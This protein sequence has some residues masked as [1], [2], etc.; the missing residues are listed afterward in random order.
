ME[1]IASSTATNC[2][3]HTLFLA[4]AS[5]FNQVSPYAQGERGGGL[6]LLLGCSTWQSQRR[7]LL[8]PAEYESEKSGAATFISHCKIKAHLRME[9]TEMRQNQERERSWDL[10]ICLNPWFQPFLKPSGLFRYI[11][12]YLLFLFK[13]HLNVTCKKTK[14]KHTKRK[15]WTQECC[16]R[17]TLIILLNMQEVATDLLRLVPQLSKS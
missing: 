12:Q 11:S 15:T 16:Q 13:S 10:M 1:D 7:G 2:I 9:S 3:C 17:P 6:T 14:Q 8:F 4:V 5:N